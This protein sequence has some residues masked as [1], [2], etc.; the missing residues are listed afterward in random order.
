MVVPVSVAGVVE[1]IVLSGF[2]VRPEIVEVVGGGESLEEIQVRFAIAPI[3]QLH[4]VVHADVADAGVG[5]QLVKMEVKI[6]GS[7]VGS[8]GIPFRPVCSVAHLRARTEDG[9]DFPKQRYE[10]INTGEY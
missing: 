5:P 1:I 8:I 10:L 7:V 4:I 9:P 3:G 2:D 6:P